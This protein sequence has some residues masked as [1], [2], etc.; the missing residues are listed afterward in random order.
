M[1]WQETFILVTDFIFCCWVL[2]QTVHMFW[3]FLNHMS[4]CILTGTC[5]HAIVILPYMKDANKVASSSLFPNCSQWLCE[6]SLELSCSRHLSLLFCAQPG[7][8]LIMKGQEDVGRAQPLSRVIHPPHPPPPSTKARFDGNARRTSPSTGNKGAAGQ[9]GEFPC[10][11]CGRSV[12]RNITSVTAV[13][14]ETLAWL[15]LQ[16]R[17]Q[18]P[19]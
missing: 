4:I 11:K 5:L 17:Q 19:L 12:I 1:T 9:E 16:S 14:L 7:T 2:C 10:K 18:K 13:V 15:C 6:I 3:F 8:V